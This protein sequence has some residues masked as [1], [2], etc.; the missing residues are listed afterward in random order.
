MTYTF[1]RPSPSPPILILLGLLCFAM[2][3]HAQDWTVQYFT[4]GALNQ[5]PFFGTGSYL[6]LRTPEGPPIVYVLNNPAQGWSNLGAYGVAPI[7]EGIPAIAFTGAYDEAVATR[8]GN[9]VATPELAILSIIPMMDRIAGR[10]NPPLQWITATGATSVLRAVGYP[11]QRRGIVIE[12]P[13]ARLEVIEWCS[14]LM[15]AKWLL[16]LGLTLV[17]GA[18]LPWRWALVVVVGAPLIAIEANILRVAGIG[19]ALEVSGYAVRETAKYW[20]GYAALAAGIVQV[21]GLA[22]LAVR[23][24][25]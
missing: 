24:N 2:P 22:H 20:L 11:A 12:L 8:N 1:R 5:Q 7:P 4:R 18:R 16:F 21:T 15:S 10:L 9:T 17:A 23:R 13:A 25:R 19:I 6:F 14:G 3:A